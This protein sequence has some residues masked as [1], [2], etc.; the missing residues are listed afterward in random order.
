METAKFIN[1]AV[2]AVIG[3]TVAVSSYKCVKILIAGQTEGVPLS[4]SL[5]KVKRILKAMAIISCINIMIGIIN[6]YFR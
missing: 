3:L 6:S 4:D 2:T 1:E 5:K